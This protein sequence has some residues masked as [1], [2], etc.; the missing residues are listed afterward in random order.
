M[1]T[2]GKIILFVAGLY[3][4]FINYGPKS[5]RIKRLKKHADD[6]YNDTVRELDITIKGKAFG[7]KWTKKYNPQAADSRTK[8]GQQLKKKL[9]KVRQNFDKAFAVYNKYKYDQLLLTKYWY[10]Y[11]D[12][13][14]QYVTASNEAGVIEYDLDDIND[15]EALTDCYES[16]FEQRASTSDLK[17]KRKDDHRMKIKDDTLSFG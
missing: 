4:I 1:E 6:L 15:I 11:N 7:F 9:A 2:L 5:F 17:L 16:I 14:N 3:L 8:G 12:L 10:E 13:L